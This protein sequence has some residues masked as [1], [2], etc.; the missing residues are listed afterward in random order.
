MANLTPFFENVKLPVISEV[1]QALIK[2]LDDEDASSKEVGAIIARDPALTAKLMRLAN[3]ARF[4]SS[5]GV[6]SLN[7][8]I[9]MAGMA[10]I[11]TLALAACFAESFPELPG[12]DTDEFWKSSMACAGYAKWLETGLGNDGQDAWLA[13]MMMR[14]GELLIYQ[15]TPTA[16]AEIEQ[17]PHLPG[18]RW[19]RE[20][21][22]L[23]FSEGE[24][25]A[26]LGRRW[27]FPQSIVRALECS[28]DPMAAKP[29]SQMGAIIHLASL[30][31]D[32]PSDDPA[33]LD[34]L[35][36]D[37]VQ[38]LQLNRDWMKAKFPSHQSFSMAA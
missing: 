20:Q 21:R 7:E 31:A 14:L 30:L 25:T 2:T 15:V 26:E 8:A 1:A 27:N 4:G 23:G 13:G 33:I 19:E 6:S 16:F 5:R 10:H 29:F 11:R 3:S 12:L 24:I 35:P 28:S 34:T 9:A 32:T 36:Q 17:Q 18:G 38:A 37:V 22:L